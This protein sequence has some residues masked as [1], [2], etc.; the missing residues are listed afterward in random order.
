MQGSSGILECYGKLF[1]FVITL[2][3]GTQFIN[4]YRLMPEFSLLKFQ[5]CFFVIFSGN[6]DCILHPYV[7]ITDDVENEAG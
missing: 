5:T 6:P 1:A 7:S 2:F 3:S 4:M